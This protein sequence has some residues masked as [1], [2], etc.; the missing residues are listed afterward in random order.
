MLKLSGK[1]GISIL[2][3][4]SLLIFTKKKAALAM[5]WAALRIKTHFGAS[6]AQLRSGRKKLVGCQ[7]AGA[8]HL[9]ENFQTLKKTLIISIR[10]STQ[11]LPWA[12][13]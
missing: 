1:E 12:R 8:L 10:V 5:F 11:E 3:P 13:C 9:P 4:V 2:R 6:G 7:I